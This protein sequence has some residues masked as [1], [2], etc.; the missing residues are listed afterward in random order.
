MEKRGREKNG[1]EKKRK[2]IDVRRKVRDPEAYSEDGVGE[3]YEDKK[4][5]QRSLHC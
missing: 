2:I 3:G 4:S 5:R 1:G